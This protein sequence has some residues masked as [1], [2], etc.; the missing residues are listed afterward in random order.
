MDL[1]TFRNEHEA[2]LAGS[3]LR[4]AGIPTSVSKDDAGG[5]EPHLQL[6]GSVRLRVPVDRFNRASCISKITATGYDD[7]GG[8]PRNAETRRLEAPCDELPD[9]GLSNY[10]RTAGREHSRVVRPERHDP[11]DIASLGRLRPLRVEPQNLRRRIARAARRRTPYVGAQPC[12][13]Y[14]KA[15]H[16]QSDA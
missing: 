12:N 14:G 4:G 5:M 11:V 10:R 15:T 8:F 3:R 1:L 2:K 9:R 6:S 7:A 13:G 16:T